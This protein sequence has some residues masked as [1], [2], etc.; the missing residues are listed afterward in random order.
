MFLLLFFVAMM[1]QQ[2]VAQH[3]NDYNIKE[4]Y[5]DNISMD[6]NDYRPFFEGKNIKDLIIWDDYEEENKRE[7]IYEGDSLY[8]YMSSYDTTRLYTKYIEIFSP[9][10]DVKLRG[11]KF[12]VN[13]DIDMFNNIYPEMDILDKYQKY[14]GKNRQFFSRPAYFG[15]PLFLE[16]DNPENPFYP[17][18]GLKFQIK[19]G[20]IISI[21]IDFRT[22]GD[23]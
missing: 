14:I 16:T 11:M 8:I 15:I 2:I 20:I 5:V 18:Q 12:R 10:Y 4:I 1:V 23:F 13:M 7:V 3:N 22:D 21:I 17:C 9:K 19:E 6:H